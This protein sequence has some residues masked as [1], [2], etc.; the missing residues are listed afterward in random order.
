M[1][2]A[3]Y[4]IL[5]LLA[6]FAALGLVPLFRWM[7]HNLPGIGQ[8]YEAHHTLM[9]T[10]LASLAALCGS[11]A[12]YVLLRKAQAPLER[13]ETRLGDLSSPLAPVGDPEL[14]QAIRQINTLLELESQIT[15][16]QEQERVRIARELH[17]HVLQDL[18]GSRMALAR[19]EQETGMQAL[20]EAIQTLRE[21]IQSIAPP[22]VEILGLETAVEE[23]AEGLGLQLEQ[24]GLEQVAPADQLE[25]YRLIEHALLNSSKHGKAHRVWVQYQRGSLTIQDDGVGLQGEVQ[26]GLG[27]KLCQTQMRFRGGN[28]SLKPLE[29]GTELKLWW[30]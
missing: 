8:Y 24:Q 12:T 13:L 18:I 11:M 1:R 14:D 6:A 21:G 17:D 27:L 16:L 5:A 3:D 15:V 2:R 28:L 29:K 22:A 30:K 10:L 25:I 7:A 19:G 26:L 23:R 4:R 9:D 20:Q